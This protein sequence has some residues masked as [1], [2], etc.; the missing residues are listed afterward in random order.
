[1]LTA[2]AE[3]ATEGYITLSWNYPYQPQE[4]LVMQLAIDPGF[5]AGVRNLALGEQNRV[6]ISGLLDGS[7]YARLV[8]DTGRTIAGPLGFQVKHRNLADALLLFGIGLALFLG[9]LA[10]MLR[11]TLCPSREQ[12]A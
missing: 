1:M 2:D 12:V 6:H 7:Y 5:S 9:L 4:R 11:F 10:V 3:I 8:T